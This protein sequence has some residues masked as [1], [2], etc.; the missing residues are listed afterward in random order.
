MNGTTVDFTKRGHK[1]AR[2][3]I[4][5][6]KLQASILRGMAKDMPP[7]QAMVFMAYFH[8]FPARFV[9]GKQNYF[10]PDHL[11]T[12]RQLGIKRRAYRKMTRALAR[13]GFL[14]TRRVKPWKRAEYRVVFEKLDKYEHPD[15]TTASTT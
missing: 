10:S 13:L 8:Q 4:A 14:E 1:R 3:R 12:I 6:E 9:D 11:T 5:A 2:Q 7:M 15:K